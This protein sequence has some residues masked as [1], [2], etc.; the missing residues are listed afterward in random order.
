MKSTKSQ[1]FSKVQQVANSVKQN[2]RDKGYIIPVK[3]KDGSINFEGIHVRKIKNT[4]YSV[5]DKTE[6]PII[7]NLNLLE[8]AVVLANNAALGR[9]LDMKIVEADKQYGYHS[10][11]LDVF[12]ARFN[13]AEKMTDTWV[14]Y[15]TRRNK[16]SE[17]TQKYKQIVY[18]SFNKLRNLR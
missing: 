13:N 12:T 11:K 16:A 1:I 17:N 7:E 10:F 6:H 18:N 5:Y 3:E 9:F 8:T 2:L 14:Y 15:E 4:F